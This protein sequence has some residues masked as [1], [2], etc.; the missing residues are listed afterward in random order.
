VYKK[1]NSEKGKNKYKNKYSLLQL[2]F[3]YI[4]RE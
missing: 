2:T 1:K 3:F 4:Y